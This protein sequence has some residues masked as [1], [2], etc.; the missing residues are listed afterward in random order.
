MKLLQNGKL[1][2]DYPW[3]IIMEGGNFLEALVGVNIA[4]M[5]R[6]PT[7]Q[8]IYAPLFSIQTHPGQ[9]V[10]TIQF[11]TFGGTI[12]T[13]EKR[14]PFVRIEKADACEFERIDDESNL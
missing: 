5:S 2:E 8:P 12:I 10:I 1:K 3:L 14:A 4:W 9:V 11:W 6:M 7:I 13:L